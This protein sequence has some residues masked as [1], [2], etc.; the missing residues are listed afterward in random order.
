MSQ[1]NS[2][3]HGSAPD[4]AAAALLLVDVVNPFDFPEADDLLR[5]ARPVAE[6]LAGL[7]ARAKAAGLPVV[8]AND[9][10]G[11]WRSD[12]HAVLADGKIRHDLLHQVIVGDVAIPWHFVPDKNLGECAGAGE[13][14]DGSESE[15]FHDLPLVQP[16]CTADELNYA[17]QGSTRSTPRGRKCLEFRVATLAPWA[18]AIAAI[19]P[20]NASRSGLP[21]AKPA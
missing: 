3:L 15:M 20:S 9:N 4:K 21:A 2:D 5:H 13:G 19:C 7:K 11:R 12:I 1:R 16:R 6:R 18:I 10:F 8:Y 14:E 17:A